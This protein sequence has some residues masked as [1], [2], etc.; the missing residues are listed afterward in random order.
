MSDEITKSSNNIQLN[1]IGSSAYIDQVS[2]NRKKYVNH[3]YVNYQYVDHE[4][5]R[6]GPRAEWNNKIE[7]ILSVIGYAVGLGNI[8]RFPYL[9]YK[10]GGG[11]FLIP[12]I[13]M[14]P[15]MDI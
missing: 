7:F 1:N 4:E 11:S 2:E 9:A 3:Q 6:S 5:K 8:W 13:I 15:L 10:Y 14:L 12:Y